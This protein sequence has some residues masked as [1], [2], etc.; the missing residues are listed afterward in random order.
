MARFISK[1]FPV[2]NLQQTNCAAIFGRIESVDGSFSKIFC[3][4][5][6]RDCN[7]ALLGPIFE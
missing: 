4:L 1:P 2:E 7:E 3:Y 5:E 6:N